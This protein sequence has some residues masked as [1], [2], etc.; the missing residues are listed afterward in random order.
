MAGKPPPKKPAQIVAGVQQSSRQVKRKP[1]VQALR[2]SKRSKKVVESSDKNEDD[3]GDS[4]D[5][6]DKDADKDV[7][8]EEDKNP[9]D[10]LKELNAMS[11]KDVSKRNPR[12]RTKDKQCAD[13]NLLFKS[14]FDKDGLLTGYSC[15][16]CR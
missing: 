16:I 8:S 10:H 7:T 5:N 9:S 2:T 14:R 11:A 6:A 1:S 4:N 12:V 15:N 13:V 3:E